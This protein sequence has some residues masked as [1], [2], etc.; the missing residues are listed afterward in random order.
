MDL[1]VLIRRQT[2]TTKTQITENRYLTNIK[3]KENG[4]N[5]TN[6]TVLN[7]LSSNRYNQLYHM[8]N[9]VDKPCVKF[10]YQMFRC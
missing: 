10:C 3:F 4:V 7:T 2:V 9:T 8:S 1:S 5:H 6:L